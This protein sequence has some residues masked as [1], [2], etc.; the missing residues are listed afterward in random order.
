[1]RKT[2]KLLIFEVKEYGFV[3][4]ALYFID[5]FNVEVCGNWV[6]FRIEF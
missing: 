3:F 5:I 2:I 4:M 1:M 6:F